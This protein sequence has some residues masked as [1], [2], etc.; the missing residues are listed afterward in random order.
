MSDLILICEDERDIQELLE[1]NLRL[2]GFNTYCVGRGDKIL[3][4]IHEI[5]PSLVLLDL[6][7]PGMS[8]SEVC[9]SIREDQTFSK[10]PIIMVTAKDTEIDRILGLEIGAD[11]YMTKPFSPKELVARVKA[12]L[13][14]AHQI[15]VMNESVLKSGEVKVDLKEHKAFVKGE[16]LQLTLTEFKILRELIT[17]PGQVITRGKLGESVSGFHRETGGNS[18]D[19]SRTIDVHLVALRK[20]MGYAGELIETV[21]GVGYRFKTH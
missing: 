6:M 5:K 10:L 17:L 18:Y 3:A 1:Y 2:D 12:V 16:E 13:R 8:G 19:S 14:R 9:R 21:R 20:K 11:D 7:M 15:P 4:A